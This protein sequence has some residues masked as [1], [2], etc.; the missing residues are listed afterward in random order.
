MMLRIESG[1]IHVDTQVVTK[2]LLKQKDK[3][4]RKKRSKKLKVYCQAYFGKKDL[5]FIFMV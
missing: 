4:K 3:L 5:G 1:L 2:G